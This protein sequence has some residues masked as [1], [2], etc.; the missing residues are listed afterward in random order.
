MTD[1]ITLYERSNVTIKKL[2]FRLVGESTQE[3]F[4]RNPKKKK[5]VFFFFFFSFC[6][7]QLVTYLQHVKMPH[8]LFLTNIINSIDSLK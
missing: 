2:F 7:Q 6:K 5:K 3:D 4:N 1:N 8:H